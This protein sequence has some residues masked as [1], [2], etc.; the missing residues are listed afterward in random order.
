MFQCQWPQIDS[1]LI[2]F[3]T[4][5]EIILHLQKP[6]TKTVKL[7]D[8]GDIYTNNIWA[9]QT[10]GREAQQLIPLRAFVE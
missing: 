5:E 7:G 4:H 10:F 1:Q 3:K 2:T 8:H 9:T 6:I